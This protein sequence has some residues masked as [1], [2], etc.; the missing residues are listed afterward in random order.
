MLQNLYFSKILYDGGVFI[1]SRLNSEILA[2]KRGRDNF[3][4][5]RQF[6]YPQPYGIAYPSGSP[7]KI[8]IDDM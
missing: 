8:I 3:H 4:M 2:T 6:F 5:G 7:F 1:N